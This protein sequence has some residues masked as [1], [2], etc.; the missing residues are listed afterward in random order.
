MPKKIYTG[1]VVS[2]KMN[3]TVIVA[4]IKTFQHPLYKKTIKKITRFKSHD[5]ENKCKLG[6]MVQIIE[7]KPLSRDKRWQ[8]TK[9][10]K[11]E[12]K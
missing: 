10:V 7:S 1:K 3:K 6:D 12:D 8:V 4:V 5:E 9:I 2:D 11:G